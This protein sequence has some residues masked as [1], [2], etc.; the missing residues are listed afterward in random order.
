MLPDV[1]AKNGNAEE[2][3][4]KC[5]E[6]SAA[7]TTAESYPSS[8]AIEFDVRGVDPA[9]YDWLYEIFKFIIPGIQLLTWTCLLVLPLY[10]YNTRLV[11]LW[12]V[13][14]IQ[15]LY[16]IVGLTQCH[17]AIVGAKR[18]K[19]IC[20]KYS[21]LGKGDDLPDSSGSCSG[22]DDELDVDSNSREVVSRAP[23]MSH[24][25]I[26]PNYS[27]PEDLLAETLTFLAS[28]SLA[29]SYTVV[30]AMED[31]EKDHESK[32]GRLIQKFQSRFHRIL[33][34]THVL[35]DKIEARG[36]ASN[37]SWACRHVSKEVELHPEF[38][39]SAICPHATP[40]D[41]P[42]ADNSCIC[43]C[44][45]CQQC[46][47]SFSTDK[48]MIHVLDADAHVHEA[49]TLEVEA[50]C[51]R[52]QK[53]QEKEQES[54]SEPLPGSIVR[55][56]FAPPVVMT[57]NVTEVPWIT[58]M[59]DI[60]WSAV[61][62]QNLTSYSKI[63]FPLSNYAFT[64]RLA[65]D[66]GFHDTNADAIAEDFHFFSK[67]FFKTNGACQLQPIYV[68]I[69]MLNLNTDGSWWDTFAARFVQAERHARVVTEFAYALRQVAMHPC[70]S[71]K[72]Y[73][74][75]WETFVAVS[76][77]PIIPMFMALAGPFCQL[78]EWIHGWF[79]ESPTL[80]FLLM[81]TQYFGLVATIVI[82]CQMYAFDS[83]TRL[84][85]TH[86]YQ[87]PNLTMKETCL[88]VPM[89]FFD[90]WIYVV[91]AFA[92]ATFRSIL[93]SCLVKKSYVV[94]KKG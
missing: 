82:A 70:G 88:P 3:S 21:E 87:R 48:V 23:L 59:H 71:V 78:L 40:M 50:D 79:Q 85:N 19:E 81:W 8:D 46:L 37:D 6:P 27:E 20:L 33:F 5:E 56:I 12:I 54:S 67:A 24:V 36:K 26:I 58:R 60:S 45:C 14:G 43:H 18:V 75:L 10:S 52:I 28:H 34:T 49:Y 83:A 80:Y 9:D 16:A 7:D 39:A 93:P 53:E 44:H 4:S 92:V 90:L 29:P 41:D 77:P 72:K 73:H 86:L 30:L 64:L 55:S 42:E 91:G 66:I 32:A 62:F 35:Q 17:N 84:T 57:R 74:A 15:L 61:A 11:W 51:R 38:Y 94:A 1:N 2:L 13:A 22:T 63:G 89:I 47:E 69:N 76:F 25:F 31:S 65:E 68:P